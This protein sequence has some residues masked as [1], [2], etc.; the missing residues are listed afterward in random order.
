M[1]E[2]PERAPTT[3]AEAF[4]RGHD[5]ARIK[6]YRDALL[7]AVLVG[8]A[9]AVSLFSPV[10]WYWK[11]VIFLAFMFVIGVIMAALHRRHEEVSD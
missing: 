10:A 6:S 1:T 11:V 4:R 9:L 3:H 8:A 7:R 2:L 5:D